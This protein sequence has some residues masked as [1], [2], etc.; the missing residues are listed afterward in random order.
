MCL[1]STYSNRNKIYSHP[2]NKKVKTNISNSIK[3]LALE[4]PKFFVLIVYTLKLKHLLL[5]SSLEFK[6]LSLY[7][8]QNI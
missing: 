8:G 3:Y 5:I 1:S 7:K 4:I 6:E 2:L